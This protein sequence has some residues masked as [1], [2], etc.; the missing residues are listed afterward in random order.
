MKKE[1]N[2][3]SFNLQNEI[4]RQAVT[5]VV[6]SSNLPISNVYFILKSVCSEI[7]AVYHEVIKNES[8]MEN[9]KEVKFTVKEE[10]KE[11]SKGK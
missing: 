2:N 9:T 6:G 11:E 5:N 1:N 8:Q 7:E 4:L 10:N 3:H